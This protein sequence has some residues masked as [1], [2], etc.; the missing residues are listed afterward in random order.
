MSDTIIVSIDDDDWTEISTPGASGLIT[1]NGS[2]VIFIRESATNPNISIKNG[3]RLNIT[4]H[5][6]YLILG[7]QKIFARSKLGAGSVVITPD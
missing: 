5:F 4:D 3:H 1:N 7:N 6:R 2:Q